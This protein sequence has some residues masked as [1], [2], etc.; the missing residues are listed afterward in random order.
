MA[1]LKKKMPEVMQNED[2]PLGFAEDA[3]V[4]YAKTNL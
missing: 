4:L 3:V 2:I 1:N